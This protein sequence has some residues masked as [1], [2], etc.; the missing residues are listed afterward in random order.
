V[1]TL[2]QH[3]V[4]SL[5]L[6]GA[7][8]I[9]TV[10]D[11]DGNSYKW[12]KIGDQFWMAENLKVTH[13]QGGTPIQTSADPNE[14]IEWWDPEDSRLQWAYDGNEDNA[15]IYGRLYTYYAIEG[16]SICPSG[17]HVPFEIEVDT[18]IKLLGGANFAGGKLKSSNT[19]WANPNTG[20]TNESGFN[21]L[22]SGLRTTAGQFTGKDIIH[23]FWGDNFRRS[24][25]RNEN[26]KINSDNIED[27]NAYS[28]RCVKD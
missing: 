12:V 14:D 17:W 8:L 27:K 7:G 21:A 24:Y 22:P 20:A 9:G 25:L 5:D 18:L 6:V 11:Y 1:G 4:D 3:G 15:G 16:D 19:L 28:L 10:Q 23:I 13:W 2:E 26:S